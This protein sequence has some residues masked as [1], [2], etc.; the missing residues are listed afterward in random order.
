MTRRPAIVNFKAVT[1]K[2]KGL[3]LRSNQSRLSHKWRDRYVGRGLVGLGVLKA[4]SMLCQVNCF[5]GH[6]GLRMGTRVRNAAGA[7]GAGRPTLECRDQFGR[8]SVTFPCITDHRCD[9]HGP[10]IVAPN[11]PNQSLVTVVSRDGV[12]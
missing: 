9:G 1:A 12:I 3:S 8:N 10:C 11:E 6:A 4:P 2:T 7:G 5:T